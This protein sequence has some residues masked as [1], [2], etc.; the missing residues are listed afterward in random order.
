MASTKMNVMMMAM[1]VMVGTLILNDEKVSAQC[2]GKV[3]LTELVLQ[4]SQY[5]GNNGPT[6]PPL[7]ACCQVVKQ[8]DIPCGC[9]LVTPTIEQIVSMEKVIFVARSCGLQINPG[10]KCGSY[11]VPPS[12]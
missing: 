3:P 10:F 1:L 7:E 5:I 9:Q 11:T 12:A 6:I 4:C 8:A 2:D